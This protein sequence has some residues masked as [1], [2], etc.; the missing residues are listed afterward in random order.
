MLLV[1]VFAHFGFGL[2]LPS[3]LGQRTPHEEALRRKLQ[4]GMVLMFEVFSEIVSAPGA[5]KYLRY[6][7]VNKNQKLAGVQKF[8]REEMIVPAIHRR[9]SDISAGHEVPTDALTMMLTVT[10]DN[11]PE[12]DQEEICDEAVL[13]MVASYETTGNTMLWVF[14]NLGKL[15]LMY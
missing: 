8:I 11:V 10:D 3:T 4:E 13:M 14:F 7:N 2:E 15:T 9:K 1:D 12:F 5:T 6:L